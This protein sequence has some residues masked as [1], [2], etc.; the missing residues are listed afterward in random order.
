MQ[1]KSFFLILTTIFVTIALLLYMHL[2]SMPENSVSVL[3][4]YGSSGEEV[5]KI[6][7]RLLSWGYYNG[8]VDGQYGYL[9]Y[10]AVKNFQAKNGLVVDGI[11]GPQTL[12]AL[13]LPTGVQRTGNQDQG[14]N[15]QADSGDLYLLARLI[16]GEARGEPYEGK[17]AV[18]AVVLN[19][20]RDSRFP[21]TIAGVIYQPGAFDAVYD[22]Q[23]NIPPDASSINA[24]RDALNGWDPSYGC[25]YYY[26][27]ST[28]TSSWIW[29]RQIVLSIG[30]HN[31]AM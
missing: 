25:V 12:E 26:N 20:T 10:S 3:S 28:A 14:G 4:G 30:K 31:F 21:S 15:T 16:H 8:D 24:A 22:G 1:K 6:Q 9:T 2:S 23:I 7:S 27:P 17:V 18:G 29:T 11:A 5:Y 19:R 13:G